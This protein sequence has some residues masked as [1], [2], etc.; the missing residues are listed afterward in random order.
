MDTII[1]LNNKPATEPKKLSKV[2]L[3]RLAIEAYNTH[4]GLIITP[5]AIWVSI[6]SQVA[7]YFSH[8]SEE[9]RY[10]YVS[11]KNKKEI[12]VI[13]NSDEEIISKLSTRI[14]EEILDKNFKTWVETKFST[15]T[16]KIQLVKKTMMLGIFKKYFDYSFTICGISEIIIK[17]TIEDWKIIYNNLNKLLEFDYKNN[18]YNIPKWHEE[19]KIFIIEFVKAKENKVNMIFWENFVNYKNELS[20]GPIFSGNIQALCEFYVGF[21]G[22]LH[23]KKKDN[24]LSI[25]DIPPE[26][27]QVPIKNSITGTYL[28]FE[29]GNLNYTFKNNKFDIIPDIRYKEIS[30]SEYEKKFAIKT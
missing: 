18:R 11:F 12:N 28:I 23:Q 7:L 2:S 17:G 25:S 24:W 10:K 27:I 14:D 20:G 29:A 16:E 4:N 13:V 21:D 5:D 19:L 22:K 15:S 6:L 8:N 3:V 30:S 26:F 9:I 1:K